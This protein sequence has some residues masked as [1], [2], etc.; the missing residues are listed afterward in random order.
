MTKQLTENFRCAN[1]FPAE[2]IRIRL[3][4]DGITAFVCGDDTATSMTIGW[5][6]FHTGLVMG[7]VGE[8]D[9]EEAT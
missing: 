5:G 8:A 9:G 1:H 7:D 2:T 4:A 3:A 6:S